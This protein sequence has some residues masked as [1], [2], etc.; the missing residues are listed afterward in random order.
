[1]PFA[2]DGSFGNEFGSEAANLEYAILSTMLNGNGFSLDNYNQTPSDPRL[3]GNANGSTMLVNSPLSGTLTLGG[4][5]SMAP[6]STNGYVS[7]FRA[8]PSTQTSPVDAHA[9]GMSPR[10]QD[11]VQ[12]LFAP[13]PTVPKI[14]EGSAFGQTTQ[15]GGTSGEV[16]G[17]NLDHFAASAAGGTA[18]TARPVANNGAMT[19]DEAYAV[20]KPYNYAQ[21][22]HYLIKHLKSRW[23]VVRSSLVSRS[24]RR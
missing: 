3:N 20:T 23:A 16:F 21:S 7:T 13:A 5:A 8:G 10:L 4:A 24:G 14:E 11:S 15:Q 18:S 2:Y 19:A 12:N 17:P 6:T 9:F 1:M 22:Y